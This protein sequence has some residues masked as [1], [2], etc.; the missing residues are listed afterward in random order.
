M[1]PEDGQRFFVFVRESAR[2]CRTVN[3]A[4]LDHMSGCAA[5]KYQR[6]SILPC[7]KSWRLFCTFVYIGPV[8]HF[9]PKQA[10]FATVKNLPRTVFSLLDNFFNSAEN[11]AA[12]SSSADA[13]SPMTLMFLRLNVFLNLCN[14]PLLAVKGLVSSSVPSFFWKSSYRLKAFFAV[15]RCR[16]RV[17]SFYSYLPHRN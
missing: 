4:S 8:G 11:M 3:C 15:T 16:Q 5:M 13:A 14:H 1:L 6:Q 7:F 9:L 17:P 10:C 2:I 12:A